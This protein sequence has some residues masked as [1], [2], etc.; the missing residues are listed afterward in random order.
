MEANDPFAWDLRFGSFAWDH[1]FGVF[2]L[3]PFRFGSFIWGAWAC[4]AGGT[5][6]LQLGEPGW[7][8]H[9]SCL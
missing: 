8:G 2:C 7:P 5:I 6:R 1:V 9:L 4:E 3:G